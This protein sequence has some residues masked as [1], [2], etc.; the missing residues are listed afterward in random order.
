MGAC[1]HWTKNRFTLRPKIAKKS[2]RKAQTYSLLAFQWWRSHCR[3]SQQQRQCHKTIVRL[4]HGSKV[5]FWMKIQSFSAGSYSAKCLFPIRLDGLGPGVLACHKSSGKILQLANI[6]TDNHLEIRV[7]H[8]SRDFF[9]PGDFW[10]RFGLRISTFSDVGL[11][12][13]NECQ[14][15]SW[16]MI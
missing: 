14:G 15:Y 4:D 12:L 5:G 3:Q 8:F 16:R 7:H 1:D 11:N 10:L 6:C 2:S 13:G 9:R